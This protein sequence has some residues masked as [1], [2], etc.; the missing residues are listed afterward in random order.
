MV[1]SSGME[2]VEQHRFASNRWL[3]RNINL[4]DLNMVTMMVQ[5]V[6]I[7]KPVHVCQRSRTKLVPQ[8]ALICTYY[9]FLLHNKKN[10]KNTK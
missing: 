10:V 1:E 8:Y 4:F 5:F 2:G 6:T 9:I 7:P 3:Y